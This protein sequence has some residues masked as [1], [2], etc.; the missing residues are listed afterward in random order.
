MRRINQ[1]LTILILLVFASAG[2]FLIVRTI[3]IRQGY[4]TISR[5]P[6]FRMVGALQDFEPVPTLPPLLDFDTRPGGTDRNDD[7]DTF[8]LKL[9][10]NIP[11]GHQFAG[12]EVFTVRV[13]ASPKYRGQPNNMLHLEGIRFPIRYNNT[14]VSY[15]HLD[16][17]KRQDRH[18]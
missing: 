18:Q 9:T 11:E 17:Y 16:V 14:S 1:L 4:P 7:G 6:D 5:T 15:T 13:L 3:L 8:T 12:G 2:W 10:S